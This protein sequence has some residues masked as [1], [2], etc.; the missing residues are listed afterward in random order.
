M[1]AFL[2]RSVALRNVEPQSEKRE[3]QLQYAAG[4]IVLVRRA[5]VASDNG[6]AGNRMKDF[7]LTFS[8][9]NQLVEHNGNDFRHYRDPFKQ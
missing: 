2:V 5:H 7:D 3:K 1:I 9:A 4:D 8:L 6:K